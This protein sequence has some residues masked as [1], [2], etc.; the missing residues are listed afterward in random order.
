M[1][2]NNNWRY[3]VLILSGFLFYY[4]YYILFAINKIAVVN[5]PVGLI[6]TLIALIPINLGLLLY[7]TEKR[8]D[9]PRLSKLA[10]GFA[11]YLDVVFLLLCLIVF[12]L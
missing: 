12:V 7:S 5:T 1:R 2:Q 4:I 11:F 10:K 8:L 6:G 9:K 3:I